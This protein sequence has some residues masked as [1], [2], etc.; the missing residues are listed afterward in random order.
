MVAASFMER[1]ASLAIFRTIKDGKLPCFCY[2]IFMGEIFAIY[3]K[4]DKCSHSYYILYVY[5]FLDKS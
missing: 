2:A 3:Q 4:A 5:D 1:S